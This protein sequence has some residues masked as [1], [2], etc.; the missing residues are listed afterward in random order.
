MAKI[1]YKNHDYDTRILLLAGAETVRTAGMA[2]MDIYVSADI[3]AEIK[4]D[5]TPVTKADKASEDILLPALKQLTPNIPILSEEQVAAGNIP[6]I[7][8]GTYWAVDPLDGTKD[9]IE[10]TGGFAVLVSLIHEGEPIL[11]LVYHPAQATLYAGSVPDKIALKRNDIADTVEDLNAPSSTALTEGN[12]RAVVNKS[13]GDVAEI[14]K[15]LEQQT[16]DTNTGDVE[17][18]FKINKQDVIAIKDRGAIY[19]FC[20]VLDG[21][22]DIYA[23]IS[24][25]KGDGAPFWD[26]AAGHALVTAAGGKVTD[27]DGNKLD[28]SP[29]PNETGARALRVVPHIAVSRQQLARDAKPVAKRK[30]PKKR[31]G[32]PS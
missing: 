30:P 14:T 19:A 31:P 11:G 15:F 4:S 13:S 26:V 17:N 8:D 29:N 32:G 28:Y 12:V 16:A 5:N 7:S 10:Q 9:F 23:H 20:P 6:D 2:I 21:T 24:K 27:F 25:S 1:A 3:G 18:Q 22:A